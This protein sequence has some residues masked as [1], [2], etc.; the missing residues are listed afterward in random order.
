MN[1]A[2]L[3]M[4]LAAGLGGQKCLCLRLLATTYDPHAHVCCV[5]KYGCVAGQGTCQSCR[6][7]CF[8][9]RCDSPYDYRVRFGYPWTNPHRPMM[10]G[11]SRARYRA[12]VVPP[13]PVSQGLP[14]APEVIENDEYEIP[15]GRAE[16]Q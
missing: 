5:P 16:P 3:T 9:G 6:P 15:P 12:S 13:Q 2:L 11:Y 7:E 10:A 4:A 14:L 8:G 1:A